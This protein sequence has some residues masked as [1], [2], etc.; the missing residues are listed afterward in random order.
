MNDWNLWLNSQET[1]IA[2]KIIKIKS[3]ELQ[4]SIA[5]GFM[6]QHDQPSKIA[7][8]YAHKVGVLEGI[9]EVLRLIKDIKEEADSLEEE[10]S[11]ERK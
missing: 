9:N 4:E 5:S 10:L 11:S 1:R 2:Q 8:D 3:E 7:V 6:L